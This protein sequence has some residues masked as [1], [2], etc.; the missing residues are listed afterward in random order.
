MGQVLLNQFADADVVWEYKNRDAAT[1]KFT[2]EMVDEIKAQVKKF[3]EL[4]FLKEEIEW[5]G[6]ACPWLSKAYLSF[7]QIYQP[8]FDWYDIRLGEDGQIK[9]TI[10][11]PQYLTT[12]C[13]TPTMSIISEVWFRLA[14]TEEEYKDA[15]KVLYERTE[16][17][18]E[19][20][21]N[22]EWTLGHLVIL[23]LV[24]ALAKIA[25]KRYSKC[26]LMPEQHLQVEQFL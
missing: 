23:V 24:A 12:F 16:A 17:K 7:L 25:W 9:V 22:A 2:Q 15:E 6:K 4:K 21:V 26:I 3:C 19:K 11:G 18:I 13:E 10:T 1:R 5:L 14:L 20:L 8:Q